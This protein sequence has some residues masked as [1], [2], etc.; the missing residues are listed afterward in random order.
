MT[1]WVSTQLAKPDSC[2]ALIEN[3]KT[4]CG[5]MEGLSKRSRNSTKAFLMQYIETDEAEQ[6]VLMDSIGVI[7]KHITQ[8]SFT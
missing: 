1:A 5:D 7:L 8:S 4:R 2:C 6:G 3:Y